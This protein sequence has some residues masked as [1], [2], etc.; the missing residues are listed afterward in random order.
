MASGR[1]VW[2]RLLGALGSMLL[3]LAVMAAVWRIFI[4]PWASNWGS[5]MEERRRPLPGDGFGTQSAPRRTCA[6]TIRAPAGEA[7]KW[8][9]Q[10]GQ[11]RGGFYSYTFLEN[12]L[13]AGIRNA[14]EIRP[15][16]QELKAGDSVRL[17]RDE[18][19]V[20]P[21]VLAVE[22][23]R[24][25]VLA[26][27]GAF[28]LEP[29]P[30]GGSCRLLIRSRGMD[31]PLAR[32]LLSLTLD[33]V[34]FLMQRRMMLGIR[35]MAE[36][37]TAGGRPVIPGAADYAWFFSLLGSGLLVLVVLFAGRRRGRLPTAACL[38][39][40][41]TLA[42][43]RLPPV[44]LTGIGMAAFTLLVLLWRVGIFGRPGPGPKKNG[45]QGPGLET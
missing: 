39:V 21:K 36:A 44:A 6:I 40:L 1:S 31:K 3:L 38:T 8:L 22:P 9:V 27:W 41:V 15:E 11:D 16:W 10:I 32:F 34:H 4:F 23:G 30:G 25:L 14:S 2:G 13:G 24:L 5:T 45:N 17:A 35:A 26:F 28:V 33:P 43:Y 29:A 37:K 20:K 19:V 7:W 12:F 18:G 42:L